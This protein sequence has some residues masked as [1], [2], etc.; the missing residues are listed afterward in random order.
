[1][2][3]SKGRGLLL[4]YKAG[5]ADGG[6]GV[7]GRP[8]AFTTEL[9]GDNRT[10]RGIPSGAASSEAFVEPSDGPGSETPF[11]DETSWG[12][13][14]RPVV[15]NSQVE[16]PGIF[17]FALMSPCVRVLFGVGAMSC[18]ICCNGPGSLD[19]NRIENAGTSGFNL[20]AG[21][22][23]FRGV[24]STLSLILIDPTSSPKELV[25][26]A[27]ASAAS[28]APASS[29]PSIISPSALMLPKLS[30]LCLPRED[31]RFANGFCDSL[32]TS[33]VPALTRAVVD[34]EFSSVEDGPTDVGGDATSDL[35][36][37]DG[38]VAGDWD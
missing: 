11:I 6:I 12:S 31:L 9:R 2:L 21:R 25:F 15:P 34:S 20:D 1:M 29:L 30:N 23:A 13:V 37:K 27:L 5:P 3:F 4:A 17:S 24:T 28:V 36:N 19:T 38:W 16:V 10:R 8:S 14:S 7:G 22:S 33:L 32:E 35:A 26:S 18:V